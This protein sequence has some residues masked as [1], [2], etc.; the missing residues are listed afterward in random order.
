MKIELFCEQIIKTDEY[1]NQSILMSL[2][3]GIFKYEITERSGAFWNPPEIFFLKGVLVPLPEFLRLFYG[4]V[5][6][7]RSGAE[8]VA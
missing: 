7:A 2:K 1:S 6:C 4:H 8:G 5:Q 3:Q